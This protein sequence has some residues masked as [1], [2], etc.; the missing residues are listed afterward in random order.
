MEPTHAQ[1]RAVEGDENSEAKEQAKED[2]NRQ[3][4]MIR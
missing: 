4:E 3:A 2:R 1:I